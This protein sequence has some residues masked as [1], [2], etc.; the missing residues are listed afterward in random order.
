[1]IRK[2]VAKRPDWKEKFEEAGFS[3]H[4]MDGEYWREGI[5]YEFTPAQI[6]YLDDVTAE[7]HGMCLAAVDHVIRHD[8]WDDLAIPATWR[9]AVIDSW[10]RRDPSLYGRFDFAYDGSGPAK[11]LEYN[12]DTPTSLYESSIAQWLWLEEAMPRMDQ[13]NSIHERLLK[14]FE[15]LLAGPGGQDVFHFSAISDHQEDLVTVEYLRDVATQAGFATHFTFIERIGYDTVGRF[16]VDDG[17]REIRSLFKLYPLEWMLSE[18][19]GEYLM[20]QRTLN[21]FEPFWKGILSNKGILA[22]LWELYPDHPNLLPAFFTEPRH[23][24]TFV[25]KPLFSREGAN[26]QICGR[27]GVLLDSGGTYSL[28]SSV[29]QE[30]CE[31][32]RHDGF[33][34]LIGSW[35]VGDEPAGLGIREDTTVITRNTSMFVPHY[36]V[37]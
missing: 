31:L 13:F 6:D 8:R 35:V 28:Q 22:I 36:F 19:F 34:T 15:E 4:S 7:L 37:P 23:L 3:F 16:F 21:L 17:G 30:Y 10:H 2:L 33:Y 25:R 5:C 29:Y 18:E 27:E 32:S 20:V 26:I 11:L 9:Q 14:R 1:M 24:D 12:A